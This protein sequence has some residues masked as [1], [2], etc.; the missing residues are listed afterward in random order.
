L[1]S[2]SI[3]T[4]YHNNFINNTR[5]VSLTNYFIPNIWDNGF[6]GNYWSNYTG[7]DLDHDGIGDSPH[8]IY[9]FD[10]DDHP[11]MGM[12]NTFYL[13]LE[14][15]ANIISNSTIDDMRYFALNST[16]KMLVS[17]R[18]V[19][20]TYGFCRICI[21]HNLMHLG[22]LSVEIN[23]GSQPVL[24]NNYAVH[25]NGTHRWIYFAYDHS[26]LEIIIVPELPLKIILLLFII[27]PLLI[28][29]ARTIGNSKNTEF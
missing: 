12:F 7:V 25:D 5:Q 1:T 19:N 10:Q 3:N 17:N 29:C 16:I 22:N 18:T 20:Q 15:N 28:T 26:T 2:A 27:A 8:V 21:P 24:F 23:H 9:L 14:R 11:L 13:T 6:E 4:I